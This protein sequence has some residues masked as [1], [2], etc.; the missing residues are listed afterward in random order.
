LEAVRGFSV[1]YELLDAMESGDA[2]IIFA[3]ES[4][5][6]M[7]PVDEKVW[8][9]A[10]LKSL[11][12]TATPRRFAKVVTPML[13]H[14]SVQSFAAEVHASALEVATLSQRAA[15]EAERIRRGIRTPAEPRG[16]QWGK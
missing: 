2:E 3:H 14:D 12:A 7:I 9:K 4:G 11:A 15:M 5:G 1:L 10:Y 16:G 8:L 6:W 13:L